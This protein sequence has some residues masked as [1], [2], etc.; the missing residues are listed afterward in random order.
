[1]RQAK[2]SAEKYEQSVARQTAARQI[3]E[4]QAAAAAGDFKRAFGLLKAAES[5]FGS[6]AKPEFACSL[7]EQIIPNWFT[8]FESRAEV[9]RIAVSADG[10][11]IA[12]GDAKRA[13]HLW[14]RRT[15]RH[16]ASWPKTSR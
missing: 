15:G 4:G 7:L 3:L 1:M 11:T 12:T 5:E 16:R 13:I 8:G 14:D 10:R 6:S 2:S 9:R